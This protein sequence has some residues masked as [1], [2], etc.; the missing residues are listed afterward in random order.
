M[1]RFRAGLAAAVNGQQGPRFS[2]HVDD[3]VLAGRRIGLA[4]HSP[5]LDCGI[6]VDFGGVDE[7][8]AAV[9]DDSGGGLAAGLEKELASRFIVAQQS[10]S[11]G[12]A[13]GREAG[14]QHAAR[15]TLNPRLIGHHEVPVAGVENH[16]AGTV[17]PLDDGLGPL[18][19]R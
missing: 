5:G 2:Q 3:K 10:G 14:I 18:F 11:G 13:G 6:G 16:G 7:T 19:R 17:Q 15:E 1:K 8:G 4:N 9:H 12:A